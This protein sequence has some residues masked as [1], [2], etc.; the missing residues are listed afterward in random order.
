MTRF[1]SETRTVPHRED[2]RAT[3]GCKLDSPARALGVTTT[4]SARPSGMPSGGPV[5]RAALIT[6][7]A[8]S[9]VAGSTAAYAGT[10][11]HATLVKAEWKHLTDKNHADAG[12]VSVFNATV[13]GTACFRGTATVDLPA[14]KLLEVVVDVDG[15]TKWSSAGVTQA[16]VLSRQGDTMD[17]FQFLDVPNWTMTADRFWFLT[18]KVQRSPE[19]LAFTWTRLVD[20]GP[21]SAVWSKVKADNSGAIEP[22]VNVGGWFIIPSEKGTLIDYQVCTDAG[23]SIPSMV[24]N[25]ATRKTLPDTVGDAVREAKRRAK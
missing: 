2:R 10:P 23:G 6:F 4:G 25:A 18:G 13:D 8:C 7:F 5:L 22:P 12:T 3:T 1:T 24:Q 9:T 17:Y 19:Q 16:K 11:T 15:S 21:H 20:G 14:E